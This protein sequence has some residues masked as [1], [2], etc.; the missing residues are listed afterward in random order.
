[1]CSS[2]LRNGNPPP[3]ERESEARA[4]VLEVH[5]ADAWE[6]RRQHVQT[7]LETRRFV[8][9]NGQPLRMMRRLEP[10]PAL[11]EQPLYH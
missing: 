4:E 8:S 9:K 11:L 10:D 1:M 6:K 2:D 5:L 7:L 3:P